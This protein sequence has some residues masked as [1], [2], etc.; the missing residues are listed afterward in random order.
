MYCG[1]PVITSDIPQFIEQV[2][3]Q[4]N[5]FTFPLDQPEKLTELLSNLINIS[6]SEYQNMALCAQNS[7]KNI[8]LN[9]VCDELMKIYRA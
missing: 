4:E 2:N 9:M 8:S 7:F 1:T 6:T 3:D 5:G